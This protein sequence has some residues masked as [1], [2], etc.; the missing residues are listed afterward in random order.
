MEKYD[1]SINPELTRK[2]LPK[3]TIKVDDFMGEEEV[4]SKMPDGKKEPKKS[5][6]LIK[7]VSQF[8][9]K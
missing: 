4:E 9:L 1:D 6:D 5:L 7:I 8:I 2:L 3:K